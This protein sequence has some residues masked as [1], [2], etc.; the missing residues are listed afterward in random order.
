MTTDPNDFADGLDKLVKSIMEEA[1]K[2]GVKLGDRLEALKICSNY[3]VNLKKLNRKAAS[4]SGDGD[5]TTMA[6]LR[7][8]F[9]STGGTSEEEN[10]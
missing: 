10:E 1:S 5:D 4:D 3:Y 6:G 2:D 7:S 9:A 8:R